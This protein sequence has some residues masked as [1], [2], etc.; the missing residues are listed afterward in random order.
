MDVPLSRRRDHIG[1]DVLAVHADFQRRARVEL[2]RRGHDLSPSLIGL[3]PNLDENGTT[4]TIAARHAG[5]SKQAVGKLVGELVRL[6]YVERRAHPDDM[7]ATLVVFTERGDK[8]LRDI[9]KTIDGIER[10]YAEAIGTSDFEELRAS[11]SKLRTKALR[12][13]ASAPIRVPRTGDEAYPPASVE[14]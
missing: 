14:S 2:R 9:V 13:E 4:V 3:L 10:C 11:L 6:G 8:L 7:R 12:T 5:I 1:R